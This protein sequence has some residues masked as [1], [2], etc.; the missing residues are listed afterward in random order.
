LQGKNKI[1]KT[2]LIEELGEIFLDILYCIQSNIIC[3]TV[4]L[5]GKNMHTI[6]RNTEALLVASREVG[7]AVTPEK[8]KY[9]KCMFM[10]CEYNASQNCNINSSQ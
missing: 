4:N 9:I 6:K 8:T 5:L 2:A 7:L 1:K 10:S 3:A